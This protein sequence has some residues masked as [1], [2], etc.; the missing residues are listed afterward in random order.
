MNRLSKTDNII[1]W[2]IVACKCRS[3]KKSCG[4]TYIENISAVSLRHIFKK[5]LCENVNRWNIC[6]NEFKLSFKRNIQKFSVCS[7]ACVV[8]KKINLFIFILN[9]LIQIHAVTFSWKI[10]RNYP[11]I[12]IWK[13]LFQLVKLI[14]WAWYKNKVITEFCKISGNFFSYA[15][16]CACNQSLH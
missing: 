5:K 6:V 3:C 2:C 8:D 16:T 11:D 4:R 10:K 12:H 13:F 15:R 14:C 7:K 1:L 9:M